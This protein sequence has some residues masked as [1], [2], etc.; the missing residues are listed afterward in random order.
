MFRLPDSR[1]K[2]KLSNTFIYSHLWHYIS[3]FQNI[4]LFV[5]VAPTCEIMNNWKQTW[6][7]NPTSKVCKFKKAIKR[8]D[9]IIKYLYSSCFSFLFSFCKLML[10]F[11]WSFVVGNVSF[12]CSYNGNMKATYLIV[13]DVGLHSTLFFIFV[14]LICGRRYYLPNVTLLCSVKNWSK[15]TSGVHSCG[16]YTYFPTETI[17]I[18]VLI[19]LCIKTNFT[20]PFL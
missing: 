2:T 12:I 5:Y 19:L 4:N 3:S 9:K 13:V 10:A 17:N 14:L 6:Y 1:A 20:M 11:F 16:K 18:K 7:T 15:V 8:I